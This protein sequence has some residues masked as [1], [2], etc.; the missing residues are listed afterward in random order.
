MASSDMVAVLDIHVNTST[1]VSSAALGGSSITSAVIVGRSLLA[2]GTS[3]GKV[4]FYDTTSMQELSSHKIGNRGGEILCLLPLVR[5][6]HTGMLAVRSDGSV[7]LFNISSASS[8]SSS[9]TTAAPTFPVTTSP[10]SSHPHRPSLHDSPAS[11]PASVLVASP[12]LCLDRALTHVSGGGA[13]H[14]ELRRGPF[15]SP[16]R[17]PPSPRTTGLPKHGFDME[18]GGS[19]GADGGASEGYDQLI[20]LHSDGAVRIYAVSEDVL[21]RGR[22]LEEPSGRAKAPSVW[23]PLVKLRCHRPSQAVPSWC[24]RYLGT[25][26]IPTQLSQGPLFLV[27]GKVGRAAVLK[28]SSESAKGRRFS[29]SLGPAEDERVLSYLIEVPLTAPTSS[30]GETATTSSSGQNTHS[31]SAGDP[32]S[33]DSKGPS[34]GPPTSSLDQAH[35]RIH[36]MAC[37]RT[38]IVAAATSYGLALVDLRSGEPTILPIANE[39][40]LPLSGHASKKWAPLSPGRSPSHPPSYGSEAPGWTVCPRAFH[41]GVVTVDG[42]I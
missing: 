10:S 30:P 37:S 9:S 17:H 34:G 28:C 24:S 42:S 35:L 18:E 21:S 14:I 11:T 36:A 2:I 3:A 32:S 4:H 29:L 40:L 7:G 23:T 27:F 1:L 31:G 39:I 41:G 13:T 16:R 25:A 38:G 33:S 20:T 22:A 5:P 19:G 6:S 12:P 15:V 26:L 8:S